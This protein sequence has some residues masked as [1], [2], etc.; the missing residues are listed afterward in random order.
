MLELVY[1][2]AAAIFLSFRII[3]C[4]HTFWFVVNDEERIPKNRHDR[5]MQR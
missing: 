3:N 5:V 2:N 1:E 4:V